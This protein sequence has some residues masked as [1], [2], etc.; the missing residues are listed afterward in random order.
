MVESGLD[1]PD[2]KGTAV[3]RTT[4]LQAVNMMDNTFS[5]ALDSRFFNGVWGTGNAANFT[6]DAL[7]NFTI[8]FGP[9]SKPGPLTPSD[10]L[11]NFNASV[12]KGAPNLIYYYGA[13]TPDTSESALQGPRGSVLKLNLNVPH[14]DLTTP[15]GGTRSDLWGKFGKLSQTAITGKSQKYDIIDTF[16][17]ITGNATGRSIQ[18]PIRLIRYVSG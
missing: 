3:N 18:V 11:L 5:V 17:L 13:T 2:V 15:A 6:N 4:Y 9:L 16:I 7:G 12:V 8:A 1:T 10:S 14:P